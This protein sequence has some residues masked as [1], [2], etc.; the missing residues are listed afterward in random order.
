VIHYKKAYPLTCCPL[1]LRVLRPGIDPTRTVRGALCGSVAA[2]IWAVQQPLDKA[3]F[4]SDY[5]DVELL[6]RALVRSDRWYAAGFLLH[7]QNGAMF[8]AVYANLAP[9]LPLPPALRGPALALTEHVALWPLGALSDRFHPARRQL[10]KFAGNR[11]AFAQST[12]RHLIF[13]I[14]LGEL[15]RR[16]NPAPSPARPGPEA[17]FSSNGHGSLEYAESAS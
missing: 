9:S 14:V 4:R 8:G 17:D 16:L 6:G 13:G 10:P 7:L 11:R 15:D 1:Q 12:W 5:D 2:A 3:L